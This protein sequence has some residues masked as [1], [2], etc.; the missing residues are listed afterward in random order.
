MLLCLNCP[1]VS[2]TT[3]RDHKQKHANASSTAKAKASKTNRGA[4][5]RGDA[6]AKHRPDLAEQV[7]MGEMKPT[8]AYR[9]MKHDKVK[10]KTAELPDD[11][12][13]VIYADPPWQYGNNQPD[14]HKVQED[15]YPLMTIDE[16]CS[17]KIKDIAQDDAVLFLWVTS[18]ILE[19]S[20]K[21]I[22][23]WGFK[24]KASFVWDKVKHNMG[25]YNSVRHEFLLICTRGSCTPDVRRLHDSVVTVERTE[26]SVKPEIFREYIDEIYP[27]GKRIELFARREVDGW[28]SYGNELPKCG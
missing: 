1:T 15:H 11:K 13:R 22:K 14:Y 27:N 9:T 6:L 20:F 7:R 19:S 4:V 5:E 26:H 16:L 28:E 17:M 24:Y 23:A 10:E 21:I 12:Y 2:G 3:K 18:P 25:H 8:E